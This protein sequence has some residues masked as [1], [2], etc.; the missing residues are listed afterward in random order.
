M[1]QVDT[2]TNNAASE[3]DWDWQVYRLRL[4]KRALQ[5]TD[6]E[7]F[8]HRDFYECAARNAATKLIGAAV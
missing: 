7:L 6:R 8:G 4:L 2:V 3:S 1:K 5:R